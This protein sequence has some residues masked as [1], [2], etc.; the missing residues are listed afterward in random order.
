MKPYE[1][2]YD[3]GNNLRSRVFRLSHSSHTGV[4]AIIIPEPLLPSSTP[5]ECDQ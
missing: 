5:A 2:A 1:A 4:G 3:E